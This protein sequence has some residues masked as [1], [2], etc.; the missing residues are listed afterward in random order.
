MSIVIKYV[1]LFTRE[2]RLLKEI[3]R[4]ALPADLPEI[5]EYATNIFRRPIDARD[6][7]ECSV[8][9][10]EEQAVMHEPKAS[11]VPHTNENLTDSPQAT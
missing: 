3:P 10:Y 9:H 1:R 5:I 2:G 6:Y 11:G 8:Y 7:S 4:I